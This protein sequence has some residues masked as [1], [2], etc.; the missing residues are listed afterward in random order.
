MLLQSSSGQSIRHVRVLTL[1]VHHH[2][3]EWLKLKNHALQALRASSLKM[4]SSGWWS[5][6]T[7]FQN[8]GQ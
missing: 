4:V 1:L 8:G 7:L 2:E 6:Y 5:E 3:L